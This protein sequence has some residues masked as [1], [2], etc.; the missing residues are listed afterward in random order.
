MQVGPDFEVEVRALWL[1][2]TKG[3]SQR[4]RGVE[5]HDSCAQVEQE[6]QYGFAIP[7]LK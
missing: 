6:I 4:V 3:S 2:L 1:I 5:G 7:L